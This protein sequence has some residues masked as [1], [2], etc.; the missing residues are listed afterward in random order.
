MKM[1]EEWGKGEG[2]RG[3]G[4][5]RAGKGEAGVGREGGKKEGKRKKKRATESW[6]EQ[7]VGDDHDLV[8]SVQLEMAS[9]GS[10]A[11]VCMS[12]CPPQAHEAQGTL[13]TSD[14]PP[15]ADAPPDS[16]ARVFLRGRWHGRC[17]CCRR[18]AVIPPK[19]LVTVHV[20][21]GWTCRE[22]R[23]PGWVGTAMGRQ[24]HTGAG[25][26]PTFL[27]GCW[28]ALTSAF[29]FHSLLPALC[30]FQTPEK[31]ALPLVSCLRPGL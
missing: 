25:G 28:Q 24:V 17:A 3:R 13:S 11:T 14:V 31:T 1:K 2:A 4:G 5:G 15:S 6:S 27:G 23:F 7:G 30:R 26:H 22:T 9:C 10:L 20:A 21:G 18:A 8:A 29:P 12:I 19:A 16:P